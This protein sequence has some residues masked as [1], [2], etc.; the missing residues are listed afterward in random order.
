MSFAI[1]YDE[2]LRVAENSIGGSSVRNILKT[3]GEAVKKRGA[4]IILEE[5][6]Y[7]PAWQ[8]AEEIYRQIK[9]GGTGFDPKQAEALS[10]R[11]IKLLDVKSK[12]RHFATGLPNAGSGE[13]RRK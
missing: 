13:L 7:H 12:L 6:Y 5:R 4:R 1:Y 2:A 8:V 9:A 3:A 10:S 11:A